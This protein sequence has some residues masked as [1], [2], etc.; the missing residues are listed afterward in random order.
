MFF[1]FLFFLFV[2]LGSHLWHMEVPRLGVESELQL[3]SYTAAH[4]NARSLAHW[5]RPGIKRTWVLMNTS[6]VRY[7]WASWKL[8]DDIFFLLQQIYKLRFDW[9]TDWRSLGKSLLNRK[10]KVY[11]CKIVME[12]R[13]SCYSPL[14]SQ[15]S[16]GKYRQK[17]Y[18]S[19]KT[20]DLGIRWTHIPKTNCKESAQPWRFLKGKKG[21]SHQSKRSSSV[22]FFIVC[23][24]ADLCRGFFFR[25]YLICV[26]DLQGCWGDS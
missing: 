19:Q 20:S 1:L 11:I 17:V 12:L 6:Q 18:S 9:V 25:H 26:V 13:C 15:Y 8:R 22:S 3:P 4:S 23:R 5:E 16:R 14:K 2:F 24:L 21:A 7:R 10:K